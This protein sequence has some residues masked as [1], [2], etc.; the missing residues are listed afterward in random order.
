ML[1]SLSKKKLTRIFEILLLLLLTTFFTC[2]IFANAAKIKKYRCIAENAS[3][4]FEVEVSLIFAVIKVESNFDEKAVSKKN[5]CGLMQITPSTFSYVVKTYDLEYSVDDIF[6]PKANVCVGAAYLSYLI[7]KFRYE[8]VALA[9]YN[10]GE[11]NVKKWLCDKNY[12]ID[13]KI[14]TDI[15]FKE[16]SDY[17]KRIQ[18]YKSYYKEILNESSCSKSFKRFAPLQRQFNQQY[19]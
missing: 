15:P 13:G 12:S 9:A 5:A 11:G 4:A 18:K 19:R 6:A 10:A 2:L 14:L 8:E 17:V 7:E 1:S 16:T 3:K